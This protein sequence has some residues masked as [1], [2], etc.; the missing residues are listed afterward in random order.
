MILYIV[1]GNIPCRNEKL[2]DNHIAADQSA[3]YDI[4]GKYSHRCSKVMI[5][6]NQPQKHSSDTERNTAKQPYIEIVGFSVLRK[7]F[8][9]PVK[10]KSR[11]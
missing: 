11:Q 10:E 1:S 4:Y 7:Y 3:C 8:R 2:P 5:N 9:S 6:W